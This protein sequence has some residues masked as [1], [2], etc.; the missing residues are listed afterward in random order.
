VGKTAL[1]YSP[2]T[3]FQV[4]DKLKHPTFGEGV[5]QRLLHPKK[6]EVLFSMDLKILIH[7]GAS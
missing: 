5:V 3:A 2:T 1:P 4:H 6:I 7:G